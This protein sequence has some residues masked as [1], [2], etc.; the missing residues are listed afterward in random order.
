MC[1]LIRHG[2]TSENGKTQPVC[3][4]VISAPRTL[5]KCSVRSRFVS[6]VARILCSP[7]M[8]PSERSLEYSLLNPAKETGALK[9][10]R[11][12][13]VAWR[14]RDVSLSSSSPL[15][16]GGGGALAGMGGGGGGG[17][18]GGAGGVEDD[19]SLLDS[20]NGDVRVSLVSERP[21]QPQ[22]GREGGSGGGSG[23]QHK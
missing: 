3:L 13:E 6:G 12:C 22:Q 15:A 5:V 16:E 18:G 2:H 8:N 9:E 4:P 17:G 14:D 7:G 19:D 1:N 11:P 20:A 10:V 23:C 21:A